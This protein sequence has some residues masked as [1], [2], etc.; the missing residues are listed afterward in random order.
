[1]EYKLL[2][3]IQNIIRPFNNSKSKILKFKISKNKIFKS[4]TNASINK[5]YM[6]LLE[7]I[8]IC[9]LKISSSLRIK[10]INLRRNTNA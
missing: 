1:M 4:K 10:S 9:I 5:I 6:K 8:V 7:V 2:M 3:P